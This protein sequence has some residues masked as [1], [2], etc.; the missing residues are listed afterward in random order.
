MPDVTASVSGFA[1]QVLNGWGIST[2]V[3]AE[4]G[5]PYSVIDYS[6]A[7]GRHLLWRRPETRATNPIIPIGGVGA[8][9]TN[10]RLQGTLGINA[11]NPC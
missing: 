11:G 3:V 10:V 6:G 2:F 5:Q 7:G 9:S 4:S 1:A 8:T